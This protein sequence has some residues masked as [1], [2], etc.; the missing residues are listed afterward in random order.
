MIYHDEREAVPMKRALCAVTALVFLLCTVPVRA[1]GEGNDP[2]TDMPEAD[3]AREAVLKAYE[4]GLM[5]GRPDGTFGT[6][7]DI[8]R[9]EFVKVLC[10]MMGWEP[11]SGPAPYDDTASAWGAGYIAAAARHGAVDAGGSFRPEDPMTRREMAVTLVRALGLDSLADPDLPLPFT[12]VT[13][14]AGYIAVAYDI[15]MTNGVSDTAFGPETHAAREQA[16]AMLTRV[17]ERYHSKPSWTHGFY[18]ISS[19]SQIDL[20]KTLDAVTLGWSRMTYADGKALLN[21]TGRDGNEY[22]I[23]DGWE[24]AVRELLDAG[25]KLHLGVYMDDTGGVLSALLGDAAQWPSAVEQMA[26]TAASLGVSGVTLDFEGL[27]AKS[28]DGFTAFVETLDAALEARG[29]TLYV[30]VMPTTADGTYFD[31]YDYRAV[32]EAADKVILMAHDYAPLTM[33]ESLLGSE[34][35]KNAA[36][37]P[38]PSVYRSLRAVCDPKTGVLDLSK[39]AL[40]LSMD[41]MAWVTDGAGR[42]ADTRPVYPAIS[43]VYR[44]LTQG[45]KMGWSETLKN[46]Y[47]TYATEDGQNIFLWYE[48]ERSAEAKLDL[49]RLLGITSVSVWRLG[50]VPDWPDEGIFF[51]LASLLASI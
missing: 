18:A 2:Y 27:F 47:L 32:G 39:V 7:E 37:T 17:Y 8:T 19:Y 31:G 15:R 45:A 25:V 49:M 28:R 23:P 22:R 42:L 46:P 6:G 3:W 10:V 43:T 13:E 11:E 9:Q 20:A 24:G 4:Y 1:A 51:D 33:P 35:Y 14:D 50:N 48:D 5:N 26:D 36:L 12:D 21:T 29:M 41:A 38:L 30:T 34:F 44:R 16:A 40:N